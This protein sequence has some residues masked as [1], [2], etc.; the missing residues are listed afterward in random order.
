[1][2]I[3]TRSI[4]L[5]YRIK[6]CAFFVLV[7]ILQFNLSPIVT[8]AS[9]EIQVRDVEPKSVSPEEQITAIPLQM[10]DG[11]TDSST[12]Q[13]ID[14][15]RRVFGGFILP[16]KRGLA[17][18]TGKPEISVLADL[19]GQFV[20]SMAENQI[21]ENE[22]ASQVDETNL[23][24]SIRTG[25]SFNRE[26]LAALARTEQAKAQT[27]QA[28]AFL[29]PSVSVRAGY[30]LE[31]SQPSVALDNNGIPISSDTHSRTDAALIVSQTLFDL[32]SFLDWRRRKAIEQ[33]RGENYRVSDGDAYISVVNAYLSLVSSRLLT[34]MTRDFETQLTELLT[35]IEKRASAGASSVSDMARVR[36]RWQAT[37]SSRLEQEAAQ[38][39]AGIEFVRLTNFVP[40][41]VRLPVL[42][43][44]GNS[45]LPE[46]FKLAVQ[47]AMK[48]NPEIAALSAEVKA[49][50]ID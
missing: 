49:A 5:I 40:R 27:G 35:Y 46:S 39:A 2:H 24:T 38:A 31:N 28:L 47:T 30:G 26:S 42:D 34:D 37:Q 21:F 43:D 1:M 15:S 18:L 16:E 29:L 10:I 14:G 8:I 9:T 44:V 19:D 22:S 48:S 33:A 7:F 13:K 3:C 45:L 25:R 32:P 41:K 20:K 36:A 4:C 50:N 23:L 11:S 12:L 17:E 6:W